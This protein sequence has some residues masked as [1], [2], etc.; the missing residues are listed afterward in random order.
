MTYWK[1]TFAMHISDKGL[2]CGIY[3]EFLQLCNK[4]N[5]TIKKKNKKFGISQSRYTTGQ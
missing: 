3:K 5:H 2:L 4:K 1:K